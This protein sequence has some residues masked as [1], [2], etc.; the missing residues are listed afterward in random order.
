[1]TTHPLWTSAD[2]VDATGARLVGNMPATISGISIDSR[3]VKPGELYVA[4]KGD[5]HDGHD[6][7]AAALQNGA[8]AALVSRNKVQ[9]LGD[10]QP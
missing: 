6:F 9:V 7:V 10:A 8:S 1:M 3:T 4:I 5:V 2:I